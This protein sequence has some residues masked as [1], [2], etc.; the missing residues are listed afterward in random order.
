MTK[1]VYVEEP[2]KIALYYKKRISQNIY[3]NGAKKYR[4]IFQNHYEQ[5]Y[6]KCSDEEKLM[7]ELMEDDY[8]A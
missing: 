4:E 2:F 5:A 1:I 7:L 6:S 8:G 3:V